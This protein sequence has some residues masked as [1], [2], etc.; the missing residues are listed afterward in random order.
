MPGRARAC[1]TFDYISHCPLTRLFFSPSSFFLSFFLS[2]IYSVI[3]QG[4]SATRRRAATEE[5]SPEELLRLYEQ[6]FRKIQDA[7]G[8]EELDKL[9]DK[10]IEVED[11]NFSL[12]NYVNELN[13]EVE[14]TREQVRHQN[15][16]KI[17]KKR[18]KRGRRRTRGK[19]RSEI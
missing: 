6:T 16:K 19:R 12:F 17:N 14:Q 9:V 7:T 13:R 1:R 10:F 11:Q 3:C 8:I 2:F 18:R 4:A 15:K 5:K